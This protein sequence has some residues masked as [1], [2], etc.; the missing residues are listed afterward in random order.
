[1]CIYNLVSP[2]D[3]FSSSGNTKILEEIM[4]IYVL[5]YFFMVY[6]MMLSVTQTI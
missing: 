5:I 1:M 2:Q 3:D 6:L 4:S